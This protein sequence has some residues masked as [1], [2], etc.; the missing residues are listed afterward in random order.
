MRTETRAREIRAQVR[1]GIRLGMTRAEL[2]RILLDR[3][4]AVSKT[5]IRQIVNALCPPRRAERNY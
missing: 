2:L 4:G 3:P 1:A 5:E